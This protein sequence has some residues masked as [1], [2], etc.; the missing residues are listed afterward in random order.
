MGRFF[1][2]LR[3]RRV[4][5][6][7][8][9]YAV[10]AWVLAQAG[11]ILF[12]T[13]SAPAWMQP[14]FIGFLVLGLPLAIVLAWAFEL[15]PEGMQRTQAGESDPMHPSGG[16]NGPLP[17]VLMAVPV[18]GLAWL[19]Y[20]QEP[21]VPGDTPAEE[22]AY[23]Q[24]ALQA[25]IK[26]DVDLSRSI[27]VLPF[28]NLSPDP[29][30]AYFSAGVH[31]EILVQLASIKDLRVIS[32]STM[33]HYARAD[34]AVPEIG[35]E[36]GV[37]SILEGSVRYS[38]NRVRITVQLIDAASDDHL[39]SNTYDRDLDDIF[40]IQTDVAM[41]IA[42]ALEARLTPVEQTV[43]ESRPTNDLNA[44]S[45]LLLADF[46]WQKT[47]KE[48]LANSLR[49]LER[50]IVLDP[51]FALAHARI[52]AVH[53]LSVEL[54]DAPQ[55]ADPIG[56]ARNHAALA[57]A[58]NPT[59]A[60]AHWAQGIAYA[61]LNQ[62]RESELAFRRALSLAPSSAQVRYALA[63]L[64]SGLSQHEEA[65]TQAK[66]AVSLD[67]RSPLTHDIAHTVYAHAGQFDEAVLEARVA[68]E[69]NPAS[70]QYRLLLGNALVLAGRQI[71]ALET[72]AAAEDLV[73][74]LDAN[75]RFLV[76]IAWARAGETGRARAMM[77]S[78]YPDRA[79]ILDIAVY[80]TALGDVEEAILLLQQTLREVGR[81][82]YQ[83]AVHS[84]LAP[85]R[86]DPR[87]EALV[88]EMDIVQ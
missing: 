48:G 37:G 66:Y 58:I 4:F 54:F 61:H 36:L 75:S 76:A 20:G 50:S 81:L 57:L 11:V 65:I 67:P 84:G 42:S 15:T 62:W 32:R 69:L 70:D 79:R 40:I 29:E 28:E 24:P 25:D 72:I 5:Q 16:R 31:E 77:A 88:S 44:Y 30:N 34:M 19:L 74:P 18:V 33:M 85:L 73:D 68:V 7:A 52:A 83:I 87:F 53:I 45:L 71:E 47:T 2:E 6:V 12:N 39:W 86:S 49:Y 22:T 63:L 43:I 17:W 26:P 60:D 38:G 27:A 23:R 82:P 78:G 59:L 21:G 1:T 8:A 13:Y 41:Q 51:D 35:E 64:L 3:R 14:V 80:L 10:V 9:V 55:N 56:A 46:E